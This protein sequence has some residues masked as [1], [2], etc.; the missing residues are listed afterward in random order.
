MTQ[1]QVARATIGAIAPFFV[2][3]NVS[4]TVAFYCEK[5]GFEAMY[6]EPENDP[7]FAIVRRDNVMIFMKSVAD[8]PPMPNSSRHPWIKW[9]TYLYVPDPDALAVE[10]EAANVTF[11]KPLGI[12]SENLLGFE[13]ADPDGYTLFFGRPN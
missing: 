10:F 6:K 9:D 3:S 5:L 8:I 7:F 4:R 2:V 1:A 13:I 11:C 12:T